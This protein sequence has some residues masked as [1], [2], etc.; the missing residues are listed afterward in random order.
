MKTIASFKRVAAFITCLATAAI[1]TGCATPITHEALVPGTPNIVKQHVQSVAVTVS[2][3]TETSAAGKSGV[4]DAE[5]QKAVAA[6]IASNK[7]FSRVVE[8]KN[9]DYILNVAIFDVDQPSFGFSFT[10]TMEMGWTLT[11]ADTGATVWRESIKST[12]TATAGEAFAGVT[13]LRL[14]TEGALRNNIEQGLVK[15][16]ALSL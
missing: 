1:L 3:G 11:R 14:A 15:L 4:S 12:H 5:L 2:G 6:A 7:V 9:G 16:S 8:G 13:R 10:V